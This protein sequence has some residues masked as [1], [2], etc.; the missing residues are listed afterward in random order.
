MQPELL[1]KNDRGLMEEVSYSSI[2]SKLDNIPIKPLRPW[3]ML[4]NTTTN[5][6][7]YRSKSALKTRRFM[8][9]NHWRDS[10]FTLTEYMPHERDILFSK[11][12]WRWNNMFTHKPLNYI[13]ADLEL[14][15]CGVV[16]QWDETLSEHKESLQAEKDQARQDEINNILI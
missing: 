2:I 9:K 8:Q 15:D 10:R 1:R 6:I 3:Y 7:V 13:Q 14:S 5:E 4:L 11:Q 12:L 16:W